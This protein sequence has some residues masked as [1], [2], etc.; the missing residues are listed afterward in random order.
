MIEIHGL[1]DP[2]VHLR[3][4]DWSHKATFESETRA[5]VMA[6]YWALFDMPN[7][8]PSTISENLLKKKLRRIDETA[9]CD[10]GIYFGAAQNNN[11]MEYDRLAGMCGLKIYN[12]DTTGDLLISSQPMRDTHYNYWRHNRVVAVHAE[13][14]T[15]L[16]IL[17]LVRKHGRFTHFCH[18]SSAD[19]IRFLTDAKAEG[20][21]ISVGVCP[22]HLYLTEDDLPA[23]GS[24]ARMKPELKTQADQDALWAAIDSGVVDIIETDH[25]P[26][27]L[28][29]KQSEFPPYGVPGLA[30]ALPL[31]LLAVKEG[32]VSL[33]RVIEMMSVNPQRIFGVTPPDDTVM[34]IDPDVSYVV[35]GG[36][37][38]GACGWSPFE[39][40]R[41]YGQVIENRIRGVQVFAGERVLVEAGFGE[42]CF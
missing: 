1:L 39:G 32:R 29:E 19:E 13:D 26:H 12:N 38:H 25:A 23:L 41:V 27:T 4:L 8:A 14:E 11:W 42:N 21:P 40:M 31:M 3:D 22:H 36:V 16:D 28:D 15:V 37:V 33:E 9:L 17:E 34:R 2:H 7:T 6:G 5:A 10:W 30:T 18:I 35:Q 24:F 20:L